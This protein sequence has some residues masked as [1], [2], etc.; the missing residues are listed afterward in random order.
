VEPS[1]H[2]AAKAYIAVL[3]YLLGD[4][5][6]YIYKTENFGRSW[7]LLTDGRNGI[8]ANFPTRVVREDP[9]KAGLLYAGT[10]SGMFVSEDD[11]ETWHAFQQNLAVTPI[12]DIK[13]IRGDLAISTMGRSFWV[14][15]NV[16]TLRQDA[17]WDSGDS[18][19][20]F[21]PK[22]SIR[23]RNIYQSNDDDVVPHFPPPAVVIDYRLAE[24]TL[25]TVR[26]DILDANGDTVNSYQGDSDDSEKE[27]EDEVIEDMNLSQ[28]I[29]ITNDSLPSQAGMNRFRWN[30]QH[31]GAWAEDEDD[32]YADGPLAK[33]GRYTARLTV[34]EIVL[35]QGFDLIVD[36]RVLAQGTSLDDISAQ[37]D[38]SLQ[39]VQLLSQSRKLEKQLTDEQE[40]LEG[41]DNEISESEQKR[42]DQINGVLEQLKTADIVY[43][44]PMLT[45]QISY[46]YNMIN[47]ADQAPGREAEDRYLVLRENLAAITASAQ[48]E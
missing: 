24:G 18:A 31:T 47:G 22:D 29:A 12:T 8:P 26:L 6:P 28:L 44:Q 14:L 19:A 43:P 32:R 25:G 34:G 16:T 27:A 39:L 37:V 35:E 15:D 36:P 3:R 30:M 11:G 9:E 10:D 42:L 46:L 1:P 5:K 33:P 41:K 21:K 48:I 2:D 17:F 38:L 13:V 45:G 40:E 23:Y 7:E 4:W 20:V